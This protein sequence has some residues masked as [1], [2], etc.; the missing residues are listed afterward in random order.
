MTAARLGRRATRVSNIQGSDEDGRG[1]WLL[2]PEAG[3]QWRQDK[4]GLG[5]NDD[6][7]IAIDRDNRRR[8]R[9]EAAH[10]MGG[11]AQCAAFLM[12]RGR[13]PLVAGRGIARGVAQMLGDIEPSNGFPA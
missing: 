1:A 8:R 9:G 13:R 12:I 2:L 3:P 11:E 6:A 5:R 10:R 4:R 7:V